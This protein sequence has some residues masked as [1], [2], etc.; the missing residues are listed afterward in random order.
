MKKILGFLSL[1]KPAGFMETLF[2]TVAV[3]I[4]SRLMVVLA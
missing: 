3:E 1:G 4:Q 2:W